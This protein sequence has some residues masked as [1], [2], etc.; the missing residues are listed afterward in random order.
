MTM[1]VPTGEAFRK[2]SFVSVKE[3]CRSDKRLLHNAE[4]LD[5]GACVASLVSSCIADHDI[6]HHDTVGAT[7]V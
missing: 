5:D 7:L 2:I 6:T 3:K 1:R 4:T